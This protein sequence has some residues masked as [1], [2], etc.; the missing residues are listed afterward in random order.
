VEDRRTPRSA[1]DLPRRPHVAI[2]V[3]NLPVERDRRVIRECLALESAGYRVTVIC[4]RGEL[5]L[6]HLPGTRDTAIRPFRQPF[7]GSGVFS[8]ATEFLWSFV[9]VAWHLSV[10]V[11]RHRVVAAQVCNPPDVFWPLALLMRATRRPWIFDH[12][13][14]CPELYVCKTAEPRGAVVRVLTLFEKLS[15]RCASEVLSTNESYREIAVTRGGCRPEK[16]TVVRN[17]PA[18][19]EVTRSPAT[20]PDEDAPKRIVYLGV[21]NVQDH[22]DV[23]ILAA[24]R[25]VER[26]GREGWELVVAG[27]GECLADLRRLADER[28]LTDVVRFTGWLNASEVDRLLRGATIGIQPDQRTDMA[29]LSTMA[30]TVEYL[31]RGLPVVAM[32]LRETRRSADDA[33]VYVPNGTPDEFAEAFDKLLDDEAALATMGK[34]AVDRFRTTLA[35]EHQAEAYIRVWQRLVPMPAQAA[36]PQPRRSADRRQTTADL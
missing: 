22:V 30:K 17:G 14:L 24:E 21:I 12:H 8:F 15:M 20:K 27:D 32:D 19:T 26:R 6:R 34:L 35:W 16:V 25:L 5:G 10:L 23:A 11:I 28:G 18:L 36:I 9:C 3:L 7:A 4:P 29:D 1:N 2:A 13:D 31:A 33:A